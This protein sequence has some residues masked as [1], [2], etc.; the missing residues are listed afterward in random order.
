VRLLHNPQLLIDRVLPGRAST[1]AQDH[2][3]GIVTTPKFP[4]R[5]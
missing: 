3:S 2:K 5:L 4:G 1:A